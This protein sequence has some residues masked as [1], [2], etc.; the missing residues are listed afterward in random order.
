MAAARLSCRWAP[1]HPSDFPEDATAA[2]SDTGL[3][4][5]GGAGKNNGRASSRVRKKAVSW[6]FDLFVI[7]H[8]A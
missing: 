6:V 5:K 8:P 3:N 2:A 7:P 1:D 4:R